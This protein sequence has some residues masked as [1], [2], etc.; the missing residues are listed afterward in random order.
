MV[1]HTKE[2]IFAE[3]H[4]EEEELNSR[5]GKFVANVSRSQNIDDL[6]S[7]PANAQKKNSYEAVIAKDLCAEG[8]RGKAYG[9]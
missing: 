1:F 3:V 4:H 2:R 6:E 8:T 7:L 9:Q 5:Y